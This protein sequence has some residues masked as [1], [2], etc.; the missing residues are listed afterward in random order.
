MGGNWRDLRVANE[1]ALYGLLI[2]TARHT[3]LTGR[4]AHNTREVVARFTGLSDLLTP[5][6]PSPAAPHGRKVVERAVA[7]VV[8]LVLLLY[9]STHPCCY[10]DCFVE[11]AE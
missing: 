2:F 1:H 7:M 9:V 5:Y 6:R 8:M 10:S 4:T 3:G 11:E